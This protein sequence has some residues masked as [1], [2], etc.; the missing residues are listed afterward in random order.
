MCELLSIGFNYPISPSLSFRG[1][2]KRGD[3]NP[4][5]WGLAFYPDKS[6]QV[7]K[8]PLKVESSYLSQFI[9]NYPQIKSNIFIAHVRYSNVS[10]ISY[11]NTHPFLRELNGTEFVFAH[12]RTL[13]DYEEDFETYHFKPVGETDSEAV[14]CH[15]LNRIKDENIEFR[16]KDDFNWLLGEL[17]VINDYGSFNSIFSNGKHLFCYHDEDCHKGLSYLLRRAPY[18]P[19]SLKDENYG[20]NLAEEKTPYQRGY[21]IATR[22]LTNEEWNNFES[23]ELMVIK[24]G[25]V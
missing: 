16:D 1:L 7:I 9:Q 15:L 25:E 14:F 24:N 17:R 6:C 11:K 8:E 10:E 23:G 19:V 18:G 2:R 21:I 12:N 20:I 3:S 22:P 5:G 4:H 13:S